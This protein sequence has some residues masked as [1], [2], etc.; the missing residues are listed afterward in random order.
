ML[1]QH[2]QPSAS[3]E[4]AV[5]HFEFAV[6]QPVAGACDDQDFTFLWH[7]LGAGEAERTG[8]DVVLSEEAGELMIP[9]LG[10]AAVDV[11]LTVAL[12]KKHLPLAPLAHRADR[13]R[14][15]HFTLERDRGD[16]LL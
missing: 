16:L 6:G 12:E 2:K 8:F 13:R 3:A 11:V 9:G 10:S 4:V 1:E 5:K 15:Q 7:I 14:E